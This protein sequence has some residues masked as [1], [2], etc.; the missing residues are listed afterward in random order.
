MGIGEADL[1]VRLDADQS[2]WAYSSS[3]AFQY[4]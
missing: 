4:A 1:Q 2:T 3:C